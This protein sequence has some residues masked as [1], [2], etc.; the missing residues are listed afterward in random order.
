[1]P[2]ALFAWLALGASPTP[3][4]ADA[5]A[6]ASPLATC[7]GTQCLTFPSAR[8]AFDSLL[9]RAPTV[10][11]VG[12]YHE[13]EGMPKVKSAVRRFTE[14]LLPALKGRAGAL[15]V[16]TWMTT[17]RCGKAEAKAVKA[18]EK[19]TRRPETTEDEVTTLLGRAYD[20]GFANHIL[21]V[22]CD[23]YAKMVEPS[24]QLD[25]LVPEYVEKDDDL[26]KLAWFAPAMR[27]AAAG[28]TVL[29]EPKP[30]AAVLL[31]PRTPK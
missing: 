7:G 8:A 18:V 14:Q 12:E 25:L 27:L 16:E 10:L 29:V 1:M 9:V 28:K 21:T 6:A 4:V 20:L 30:G 11:A 26:G 24:G 31:F 3:Q 13:V 23:E 17:G 5:G 22:T 19:T 2:L 15:V